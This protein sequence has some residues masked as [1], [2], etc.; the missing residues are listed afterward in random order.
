MTEEE[1]RRKDISDAF[2]EWRAMI[3]MSLDKHGARLPLHPYRDAV[4]EVAN[5]AAIHERK[6][7]VR[8]LTKIGRNLIAEAIEAGDHLIP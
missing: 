5:G 3:L 7:I 2:N 4:D 8:W 1:F 6:M